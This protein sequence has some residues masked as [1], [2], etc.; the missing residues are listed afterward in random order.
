MIIYDCEIIKGILGKNDTPE[1]GIEYCEGWRDFEN[2]GISVICAYDYRDDRYRSF[3]KDNFGEFEDL[4]NLSFGPI[5][6]FNS[7]AF[8]NMLCAANGINVPVEKSYDILVE[9]W[10]GAGLG[11]A[12][13]Y[14]SH[15]G[16]GLDAVASANFGDH[17]KGHGAM[18]PIDWQ[19]GNYGAVID[20]CLSDVHLTKKVLDKIIRQG[21]LRDPRN[22]VG[23]LRIRR[24][25]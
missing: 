17:K 14:P 21:A 10:A 8:D 16:F 7:L 6:G 12:F 18:A 3:L 20:Y 22:S 11:A 9:I 5:I 24:P 23:T 2:M 4:V 1:P 19:R 15:M 13:E 25:S